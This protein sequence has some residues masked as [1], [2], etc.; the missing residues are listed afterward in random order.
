MMHEE[1][2]RTLGFKVVESHGAW[3]LQRVNEE[4]KVIQVQPVLMPEM[5]AL[6][7]LVVAQSEVLRALPE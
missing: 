1:L 5:Y 6:W 7:C 3:Q 4:G 2:V